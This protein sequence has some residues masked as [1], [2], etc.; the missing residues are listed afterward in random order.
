MAVVEKR[1][2]DP[3][4]EAKDREFNEMLKVIGSWASWI[5]NLNILNI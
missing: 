1:F 2:C 5:E 3:E 4:R